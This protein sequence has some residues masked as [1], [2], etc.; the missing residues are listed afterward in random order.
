MIV[1][2]LKQ[3]L[4]WQ[5]LLTSL[6]SSQNVAATDV[7]QE[8]LATAPLATTVNRVDVLRKRL[9]VDAVDGLGEH[10]A[11]DAAQLAMNS[12]GGNMRQRLES[13]FDKAHS[14]ECR[15]KI[16]E[17]FGY[18]VNAI[19]LEQELPFV[20]IKFTNE[21]D[22]PVYDWNNLPKDMHIGNV[23]NRT[24]Q[25][26]RNESTYI[27]NPQDLKLLFGILTHDNSIATI[28]LIEALYE[29]G[30]SF[31]VH[32]DA[33]YSQTQEELLAYASTRDHVH[34]LRD[35]RR[36]R[37]NWGG[38][39]MVNATLQ[40]LQYAI[41]D[42]AIDFHKFVHMSSSTYPL[43]SN[44]EIRHKLASFPLDANFLY[45][46][47]QPSRPTSN[48][49]HYFVECDDALHRI[50]QLQPL[51]RETAGIDLFTSSQW[52]IISHEFAE[53]LAVAEPGSFVDQFARY[54]EHIVVA[55]ETFFGT[56]LRNTR[57]CQK[58]HNV[59]FLHL[60]FDRW[61]SDIPIEQR[62][63][64][65]CPMP[66]PDHCK[67]TPSCAMMTRFCVMSLSLKQWAIECVSRRTAFHNK[68]AGVLR[69]P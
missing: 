38:F 58:H 36:I 49:W 16:V 30:H 45:V 51:R 41:K 1:L 7:E 33:K 11:S 65:K 34:I 42:A 56:V 22:E 19:G 67:C 60:Q 35:P 64:R 9:R 48:G 32:V 44:P 24:Y 26:P 69:R 2:L 21:C 12:L 62:D 39:T 14:S 61:E 5:V 37:V 18:F 15:Q 46:I 57:Y 10:S 17:H 23:Q 47:L 50:Y 52:F 54:S 63:Q 25:P 6:H 40:L 53:Y 43:A 3:G 8:P 20:D 13:L 66:N 28:R 31:V 55:D 29:P 59:N 68:Q 4:L 27:E